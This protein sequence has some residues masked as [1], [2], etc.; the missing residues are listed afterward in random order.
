[1]RQSGSWVKMDDIAHTQSNDGMLK[2][3]AQVG[4][5]IRQPEASTSGSRERG[6]ECAAS[7]EGRK[8]GFRTKRKSYSHAHFKVYKRRWLGLGQLVLLNVVVSWDVRILFS[9][10]LHLC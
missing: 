5:D 8:W 7:A 6:G 9:I 10:L 2:N 1:M 3:A 4:D